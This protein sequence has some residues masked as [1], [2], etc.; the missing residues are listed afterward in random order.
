ME[1]IDSLRQER[2]SFSEAFIMVEDSR[3]VVLIDSTPLE[4]WLATTD[5]RD[6][7]KIEEYKQQ[8]SGATNLEI[9]KA[10]ALKYP[11]GVA[12]HVV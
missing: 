12:A 6:L 5:G 2:G 9:L 7:G 4:Y 8:M 11:K 10:L 3:S 1:L